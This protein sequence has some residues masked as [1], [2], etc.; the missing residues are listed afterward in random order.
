[1][2]KCDEQSKEKISNDSR[3]LHSPKIPAYVSMS[4]DDDVSLCDLLFSALGMPN[5]GASV[6]ALLK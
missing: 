2:L 4:L 1:M 5:L 3:D 6:V